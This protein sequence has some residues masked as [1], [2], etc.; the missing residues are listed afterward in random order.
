M[1]RPEKKPWFP[2]KTY[3]WG[4]GLPVHWKGWLF[5][6]IW[7]ASFIAGGRYMVSAGNVIPFW[8][9]AVFM[10]LVLIVVCWIKGE[11]PGWRWGE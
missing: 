4:W 2:A 10:I 7:L 3:G 9:F 11:R 5:F 8:L 6:I 1:A